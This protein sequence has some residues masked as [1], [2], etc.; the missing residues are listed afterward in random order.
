MTKQE[1]IQMINANPVMHLATI[2]DNKPRVRALALFRADEQGLI[3][4]TASTKDMFSQLEKNNKVEACF[5]CQGTQIRISGEVEKIVDDNLKAE[6]FA[7]PTR[8][9]LHAWKD[10]GIEQVFTIYRIKNCEAIYWTMERNFEPKEVI[11]F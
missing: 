3:F 11:K 5:Q 10:H 2:E 6:I 4:H 7:H 8:K 1:I 9:F